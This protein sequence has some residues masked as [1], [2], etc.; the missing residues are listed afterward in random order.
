MTNLE[1]YYL[2]FIGL[3]LLHS[4]EEL[5]TGFHDKF[6]PLKMTFRFFLTFEISF[7][8]LW[9][10]VYLL[11]FPFREYLMAFFIALMFANGIWHIVWFW[12]FEK[13]KKYVPG[14]VTAPLF[15]IAF[16]V[17]YFSLVFKG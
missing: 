4:T 6:P 8:L 10:L 16:F 13:G 15:I 9:V 5:S 17:Y 1:T 7:L 14:L 12:F 3:Q 11:N 2:I